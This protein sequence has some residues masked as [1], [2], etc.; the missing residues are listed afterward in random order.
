MNINEIIVLIT[1]VPKFIKYTIYF[2]NILHYIYQDGRMVFIVSQKKSF[3]CI[4]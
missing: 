4:N 3:K 2:I 1:Q